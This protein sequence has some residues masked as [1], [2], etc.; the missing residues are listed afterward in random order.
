MNVGFH[1]GKRLNPQIS[2]DDAFFRRASS[3]MINSVLCEK[4]DIFI[5]KLKEKYTLHA[6][7]CGDRQKEIIIKSFITI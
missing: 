3:K 2:A 4:G 6:A 7:P 1:A 5:L